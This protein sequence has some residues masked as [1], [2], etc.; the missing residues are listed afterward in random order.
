M[1]FTIL[2]RHKE[3]RKEMLK[4][5]IES[6]E[7]QTYKNWFIIISVEYPIGTPMLHEKI[8]IDRVPKQQYNLHCNN[9][10][11]WVQEG[12]F[13]FLDDDDTLSGTNV[14]QDLSNIIVNNYPFKGAY[15]TQF[16]RN[17]R[18]KPP[19]DMIRKGI[20]QKG[21]IGG[22]CMVLHHNFKNV[23]DWQGIPAADYYWIKE[24]TEKVPTKFITLVLQKTYQKG[25]GK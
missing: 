25:N 5:C 20:I 1:M 7:N 13:F 19:N 17:G 23:A 9:L 3:D 4:R 24:V 14:L 22:G 2:I 8:G 11:S 21:F 10:K 15:I 16:L 18:P 12:W 6:V